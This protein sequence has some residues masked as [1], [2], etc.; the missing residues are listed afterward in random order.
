MS[1]TA[2]APRVLRSSTGR[3]RI[4]L[5][6]GAPIPELE[7]ALLELEG[8]ESASV[9]ARTGNVL[10]HF[11]PGRSREGALLAAL[12]GLVARG[13]P[14][15]ESNPTGPGKSNPTEPRDVTASEESRPDEHEP[16]RPRTASPPRTRRA[17]IAVAGLERDP[18]LGARI[19]ELL[20]GRPGIERVVPS[21]LTGRVLVEVAHDSDLDLD[22]IADELR[23]LEP[24]WA[25]RE[26]IPRH[27]LER[28]DI[29]QGTARAIGSALGL[30]I[31]FAREARGRRNAADASQAP[32]V[33]A[34]IA[35]VS[36]AMPPLAEQLERLLG[37]ERR[38][39][40]IGAASVVSL[41]LS[42]SALG[43]VVSGAAALRLLT[44]ARGRRAAWRDYEQR[45]ASPEAAAPGRT[46]N[47]G[48]GA[49]LPLPGVV[50]DGAGTANAEDGCLIAVSPRTRLPA[51]AVLN[52]GG[53]EIRLEPIEP[54]T[55]AEEPQHPRTTQERYL[56]ALPLVAAGF[57]AA[58]G[59]ATGSPGRALAALLLVNPRPA[60]FGS[61]AA[62]RGASAR[63]VRSGVTVVGSRPNRPIQRMDHVLLSS[64]R[65][66]TTGREIAHV[67]RLEKGRDR[68]ALVNRAAGISASAGSPWGDVFP[69]A[70]HVK[71]DHAEFDGRTASAQADDE[72]W[73]LRL[74]AENIPDAAA[75]RVRPGDQVLI[76]SLNDSPVG[77]FV[78]RP[79][80]D[81]HRRALLDAVRASGATL[82]VVSPEPTVAAH[83]LASRCELE[84]VA[85]MSIA[86]RARTLRWSGKRVAVVSD[87]AHAAQAFEECD[88]AIGLGSGRRGPFVARADMLAATPEGVAA[89]IEAGR[90]RDL[91]VRDSIAL[92]AIAN[93]VGFG[94]GVGR[95]PGVARAGTVNQVAG[96]LAIASAWVRLR[97]GTRPRS[98]AERIADPQPER[99]GRRSIESVLEALDT[100][101]AGLSD[102]EAAERR[103]PRPDFATDTDLAGAAWAQIESPLTAA[104]GGAALLSYS[105][106][107]LGD[108]AMLIAVIGANTAVGIWQERQA[109]QAAEELRRIGAQ[110]ARVV[111]DGRE[112]EASAEE[113]VPG[114]VI[115]VT[116][117]DRIPADARLLEAESLEV[118]EAA[119]TGES[120]PVAK[121]VDGGGAPA[122]RILLEGT[123]VNAGSG[124]AAVVA[125]GADTR[126]GAT[127]AALA[128]ADNGESPL[129]S[130]LDRIFRQALPA[131]LAGGALVT[132]S[133]ILW[134]RPALPQLALG[135]SVAVGALPEGLPLL[136]GVAEAGVARRLGRRNALLHRLS[137]VEAL[138]RVDVACCDKTGT[139]TT[140]TLAVTAVAD[141]EGQGAGLDELTEG[142]REIL[143]AA[144]LASPHPE[145]P[146]A[147]AHPTDVA[148]LE[149]AESAG[150]ADE[151]RVERTTESPFDPARG[152]HAT[153]TDGRLVVKGAAEV[154]AERCA[155]S[156]GPEGDERWLD[157]RGRKRLLDAAERLAGEGLRV[158]MVAEAR[159][160]SRADDPRDLRVLGFV[161]ISD[162]LREGVGEAVDRCREAGVRVIMLTGDHPATARAAAREA[163]LDVDDAGMLTGPEV[164]D[165]DDAD[166]TERLERTTVIARISPLDKVRIVELLQRSGHVV[167]MTGD[168]VNDAPALR[169]ADVGVAM[170]EHGTEVARQASDM[171]LA[172]DDFATLVE[173]LVEGRGF[174]RNLRRALGLLLGGNVGE[175]VLMAGAAAAGLPP[176]MTTRQVLAVNLVTDVL[177]AVAVAVQEPESR[178]LAELARERDVAL[179]SRM[180]REIARRGTATAVP[181]LAAF[182]LANRTMPGPTASAVAFITVVSAQLAQTVELGRT[183]G[184]LTGSVTAAVG[185]SAAVLGASVLFP[186]LRAFLGV[187]NPGLV[188]LLYVG[189]SMGAAVALSRSLGAAGLRGS[190]APQEPS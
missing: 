172:D 74:E 187:G 151:M 2:E 161:G 152:F 135:T 119:L 18:A 21:P 24:E 30:A 22:R 26:E 44:E 113:L 177:P 185:G 111:R 190:A 109:G 16:L 128:I 122:E 182:V 147:A 108:V 137:S 153:V 150:L 38:E 69:L 165:L 129:T 146:G 125:V 83:E 103:Q 124:R 67:V 81:R 189:G 121:S 180:G 169:P 7:R 3:A 32:A 52:G 77:A 176:A 100:S 144:A 141:H 4:S 98:V 148:V 58:V 85:G 164:N 53:F 79:R 89:I 101:R 37:Y 96:L 142:R 35:T 138:G 166:L 8:V 157:A 13:D 47:L 55:P 6:A 91:A 33:V 112:Q 132:I 126:I 158:L 186:P 20:E 28:T 84:L 117:G 167:A 68:T 178:H 76:L 99:W 174:W 80:L 88:L 73:T 12:A 23:A 75:S 107:A 11:D 29:V 60:L 51:G 15:S 43:L 93:G 140:G 27:P 133:G 64:P 183:E 163:Y 45:V 105:F 179:D 155:A 31:I 168:G 110:S 97:G 170:G 54:V 136:A 59:I 134:R 41:T 171:V 66:L 90:L 70:A 39:L 34:G 106:G 9:S 104:L 50:V 86:E 118:D 184:R 63:A 48:A 36:E 127:T 95:T 72:A 130:R 5:P 40:A 56:Q 57:A 1:A 82:E 181:S 154:L 102:A 87:S 156:A 143:L 123:D 175:I 42:G 71:V 17:R 65:L 92:S 94:W 120:F 62:D 159:N 49:R 78:L 19:T 149:A 145:S 116:S 10:V 188:G 173:A 139:M 160:G 115:V 131:I 162:P 114:D 25:T 61:E 14:D 46:V